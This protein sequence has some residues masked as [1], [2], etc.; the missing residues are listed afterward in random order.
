[1][2]PDELEPRP[3]ALRRENLH[4]QDTAQPAVRYCGIGGQDVKYLPLVWAGIWRK[5]GRTLLILAQVVIAFTLFGVLQGLTS[6]I[7]QVV[8]S[9][10]ADRLYVG[11]RL[12]FGTPLPFSML[13]RLAATPGV[14]GT[15]YRFS[16][17]ASYQ[18]AT[19]N[20][21]IAGTDI[22]SFLS[23]YPEMQVEPA[24]VL[25][26]LAHTQDGVIVGAVTMKKYGW[27]IGQRITLQAPLPRK[28]GSRDWTFEI[29]GSV[30]N[31]EHPD[32]ALVILAN[33]RYINEA[34]A[35]Q[36]DTILFATVRIADPS[37]AARVEQA[38]DSQF[39][40]SAN[41][42]LTQS[43]QE[44]AQSQVENLGD[45]DVAVHRVTAATFFV[46]L[47]ATGALMMQSIRERTPELGVLKTIGFSSSLVM[48]LILAETLLL[49]VAGAALGLWI[50]SRL[51]PLANSFI[52][53]GFIPA[54]VVEAGLAFAVILALAAGSI[55]AWRG[56]RLRAV[57]ALANR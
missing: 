45:M 15:S 43:E 34:Q 41:E 55:P 28:N 16:F 4:G 51:L 22:K 35:T 7:K 8:A 29:L 27:K 31:T 44:L 13:A 3:A 14:I 20:V 52:G 21:P 39:A 38:I 25:Q 12:R 17:G 56:L 26:D 49:C 37:Q 19:Q 36:P 33:Y 5:R 50:A 54:I 10:H 23:M 42:T 24:Q 2:R 18:R 9:T 6:A 32:Q 11:S 46:M 47:F 40:N 57:D 48:T 53:I 1:V 30:R